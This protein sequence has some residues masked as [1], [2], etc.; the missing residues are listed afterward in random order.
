MLADRDVI[1]RL[2]RRSA[3]AR[4]SGALRR[5]RSRRARR[6]PTRAAGWAVPAASCSSSAC[7]AVERP[8]GPGEL[9]RERLAAREQRRD[10]LALALGH[11][12]GLGVGVALGA[13]PVGLDLP[14]LALLFE[15]LAA[16]PR[17]AR[18]RG[19][20]GCAPR[21]P[22]RHAAASDRSLARTFRLRA[23]Q[24][25]GAPAPRAIFDL[26]PARH[27]VGSIADPA[28]HPADSAR[29]PR[30]RPARRAR[31]GSAARSRA[32]S[33]A[34]SARCAA[35][36]APP[37]CRTARRPP[38]PRPSPRTPRCSSARRRDTPPPWRAP[39][40]PPGCRAARRPP[41]HRA[42]WRARAG[43]R[44]PMSSLAMRTTRRAM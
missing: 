4:P 1:A 39:A 18:S 23:P 17:P 38:S 41:R 22:D 24:P 33:S 14:G 29:R 8:L 40:R 28:A 42:S 34:A 27:R 5:W 12:H 13:Q 20:P 6:A 30:R 9:A 25:A 10:I 21:R 11:A 2:E 44:V 35:A 32:P 26:Q 15:R 36:A 7:T 19:A 16:P 43:R 31:S 37:A 3:A